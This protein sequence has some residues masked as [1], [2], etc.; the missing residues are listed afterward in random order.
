VPQGLHPDPEKSTSVDPSDPKDAKPTC[1]PRV[2]RALSPPIAFG[3]SR[4]TQRTLTLVAR[5]CVCVCVCC[6]CCVSPPLPCVAPS[7]HHCRRCGLS[8]CDK[9]SK[10]T[11]RLHV[12]GDKVHGDCR[13]RGRA[14]GGGSMGCSGYGAWDPEGGVAR[15]V[16]RGGVLFIRPY[17]LC[18]NRRIPPC[19]LVST[20]PRPSQPL[21]LRPTPQ[22][23]VRVCNKCF[24]WMQT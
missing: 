21:P 12:H 23:Q 24:A 2:A 4:G 9:H 19:L 18:S 10:R 5:A 16:G 20:P 1:T 15:G 7:Q 14:G 22:Y 3:T 17:Y 11:I 6:V 13:G 8:F